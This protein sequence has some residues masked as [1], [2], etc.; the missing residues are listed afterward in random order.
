MQT[1]GFRPLDGIP[2]PDDLQIVIQDVERSRYH[3]RARHSFACGTNAA[4]IRTLMLAEETSATHNGLWTAGVFGRQA[5]SRNTR[6]EH[7]V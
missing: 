5:A 4:H 3:G 1:R 6:C 2:A 7:E